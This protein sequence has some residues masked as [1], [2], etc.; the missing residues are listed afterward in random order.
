MIKRPPPELSLHQ[1]VLRLWEPLKRKAL[2]GKPIDFDIVQIDKIIEITEKS[3]ASGQLPHDF[4]WHADIRDACLENNFNKSIISNNTLSFNEWRAF[5]KD[6]TSWS[7]KADTQATQELMKYG[8]AAHGAL[9]IACITAL[10]TDKPHALRILYIL[11]ILVS[12]LG[13]TMM[14]LGHYTFSTFCSHY[15][16]R[17]S[18]K[19]IRKS[20]WRLFGAIPRWLTLRRI[21]LWQDI[22]SW[23]ITASILLFAF[24]AFLFFL[25]V[26]SR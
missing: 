19:L 9:A 4:D 11:G 5:W 17:L 25:V 23:L 2:S 24:Y 7:E 10:S 26:A 3:H 12:G 14:M 20:S 13:I 16:S 21:K 18:G 6:R 15:F 1:T 8:L 22:S